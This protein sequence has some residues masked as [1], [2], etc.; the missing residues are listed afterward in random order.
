VISYNVTRQTR[1]IGIRM[2]LGARPG[3]VLRMVLA[4]GC[5]LAVVGLGIGLASALALT[6]VMQTLLFGVSA[7]DPFIFALIVTTL[8]IMSVLASWLPARRATR[9]DPILAL[10]YE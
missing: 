5:R 2:A 8:G 6:R 7:T 4:S 9:V 10:R 1:E 3:D